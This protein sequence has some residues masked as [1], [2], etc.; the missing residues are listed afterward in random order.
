MQPAFQN[1]ASNFS[2]LSFGIRMWIQPD[3]NSEDTREYKFGRL[4]VQKDD[5]TGDREMTIRLE[6]ADGLPGSL[7]Y[8][9]SELRE[10]I[11]TGRSGQYFGNRHITYD[12][13]FPPRQIP[14]QDYD[15]QA[16]ITTT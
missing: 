1:N 11:T 6:R 3:P 9:S 12:G 16:N 4:I 2:T 15:L 13:P 10:A 14:E 7:T 5:A 8:T